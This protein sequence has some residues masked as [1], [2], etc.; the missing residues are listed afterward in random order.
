[1]ETPD[2]GQ[3]KP[4][5][6]ILSDWSDPENGKDDQARVKPLDLQDQQLSTF[7]ASYASE[8]TPLR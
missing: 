7:F 1:M 2:P 8:A 6:K 5:R 3:S 4:E